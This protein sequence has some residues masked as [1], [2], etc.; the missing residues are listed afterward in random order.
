MS[1]RV[2]RLAAKV[3]VFVIL[4]A[5]IPAFLV[6]P[7]GPILGLDFQNLDAFHDC[8]ARD[9]PYLSTGAACGDYLDRDMYYPPMLFWSFAWTRLVSL[10]AGYL[11]WVA[12]SV[13]AVLL[14]SKAW[15][16]K[17]RHDGTV[18]IFAVLLLFQFPMLFAL[19]R[20]N[21]DVLVVVVWTVSALL[22]MSGRFGWSGL[23]AGLAVALKLY[24]AVAVVVVGSGLLWMAWHHRAWRPLM[25]FALGCIGVVLI[26]GVAL[27][28]QTMLWLAGEFK[29]LMASGYVPSTAN[30][31]LAG[32]VPGGAGWFLSLPLLVVWMFAS[33]RRL[34]SDPA[35][36]FA[37]ALAISTYFSSLS[38]DYNLITAYP[39]LIM[40]FIR[41]T[42]AP[43][44]SLATALLLVGL[45]AI[46]GNRALFV[47]SNAAIVGHIALQW[48]WLLAVGLAVATS[49]LRASE[50]SA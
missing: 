10:Q 40:L 28:E 11:I 39:L 34:Q 35:L 45:V 48:V 26:A 22:F 2:A 5:S 36:L 23:A 50:P 16:S 41:A 17:G 27:F 7:A 9:N 37:G 44:S 30:H 3:A 13:G 8:A 29:V 25:L 18:A 12:V 20:G 1:E 43:W 4:A 33:A 32:I 47:F 24:P 31:A 6:I 42:S 46:V 14:A 15:V 49:R 21:N 38:N 19:E